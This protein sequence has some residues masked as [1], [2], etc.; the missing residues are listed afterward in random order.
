MGAD[1]VSAHSRLQV[2]SPDVKVCHQIYPHVYRIDWPIAARAIDLSQC[3]RRSLDYS[4][5][6]EYSVSCKIRTGIGALV[7]RCHAAP[8]R[9]PQDEPAKEADYISRD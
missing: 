1:C 9:E 3:D 7:I 5:R 2:T 4:E 6:H 8:R